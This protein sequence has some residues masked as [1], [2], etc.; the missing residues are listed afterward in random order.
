MPTLKVRIVEHVEEIAREVAKEDADKSMSHS[1]LQLLEKLRIVDLAEI[2]LIR[3]DGVF[4]NAVV[5]LLIEILTP[6][7][8]KSS[9]P[10]LDVFYSIIDYVLKLTF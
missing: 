9:K 4:L 1:R 7:L 5:Q 10:L 8:L 2:I 3:L 6:A